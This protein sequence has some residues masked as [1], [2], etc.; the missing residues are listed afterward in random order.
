[1]GRL[2]LQQLM[3][4]GPAALAHLDTLTQTN[5]SSTRAQSERFTSYDGCGFRR[6]RTSSSLP[7]GECRRLA[8]GLCPW[9][10]AAAS[11][12]HLR[13]P[14]GSRGPGPGTGWT[15]CRSRNQDADFL[16]GATAHTQGRREK[17]EEKS[18]SL[19]EPWLTALQKRKNPANSDYLIV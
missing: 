19:K 5:S 2:G 10:E 8:P 16:P 7:A 9:E 1:M 6:P 12:A 15:G 17:C 11:S 13:R 3:G 18:V 4:Q 14:P